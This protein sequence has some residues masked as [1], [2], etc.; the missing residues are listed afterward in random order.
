MDLVDGVEDRDSSF[1]VTAFVFGV[2]VGI[3]FRDEFVNWEIVEMDALD[4]WLR[5]ECGVLCK[6]WGVVTLDVVCV[7]NDAK[8]GGIIK[9]GVV[10]LESDAELEKVLSDEDEDDLV[11]DRAFGIL[12]NLLFLLGDECI[13]W[14]MLGLVVALAKDVL[15]LDW[16]E[17]L[18]E[19]SG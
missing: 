16:A 11:G 5:C 15:L 13:D 2:G 8:S 19:P 7:F 17:E 4:V 18:F 12:L 3:L 14:C 10:R 9:V 1:E 6:C